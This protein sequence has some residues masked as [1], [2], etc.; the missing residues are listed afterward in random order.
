M[1]WSNCPAV[2]RDPEKCG[3]AWC[4]AGTRM[5]VASLFEN[6]DLGAT[7]DEFLAWFP[8]VPAEHVHEVLRFTRASLDQPAKAA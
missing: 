6:L 5:P 2:D 4:F 3:G 8:G 7:V 1:D